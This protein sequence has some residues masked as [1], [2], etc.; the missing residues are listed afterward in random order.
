MNPGS[1]MHDSYRPTSKLR[2]CHIQPMT[3]VLNISRKRLAREWQLDG[4]HP[5]ALHVLGHISS[6]L[7]RQQAGN[8]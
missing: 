7:T 1:T 4:H 6:T 5:R 2:L 3:E 8:D